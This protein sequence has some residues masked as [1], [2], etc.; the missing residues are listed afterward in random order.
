MLPILIGSEN[1]KPFLEKGLKYLS[2]NKI[3]YKVIVS[4]THRQP[5][6]TSEKILEL[7]DNKKVKIIIGGAAS[8]TGLPGVIAGYLKE[9]NIMIFGVRFTKNPGPTIIEDASFHLSAMPSGVPLAY[10]GYNE[11]GF[12]HACML[13]AR[14]IK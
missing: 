2:E 12:L 1:D 5:K 9:T 7:L 10:T 3:S 11:N 8:A 4:S 13:A 6:E 14:I